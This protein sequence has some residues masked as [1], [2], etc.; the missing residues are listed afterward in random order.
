M[1][2]CIMDPHREIASKATY[3]KGDSQTHLYIQQHVNIT[4]V[5][6]QYNF[7]LTLMPNVDHENCFL[8]LITIENPMFQIPTQKEGENVEY[9]RNQ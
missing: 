5:G 2:T 7:N 4:S 9:G 3:F 1:H 6:L 8:Q